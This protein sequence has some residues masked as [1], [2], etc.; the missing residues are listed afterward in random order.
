MATETAYIGEELKYK[1]VI[2]SQGF[3]MADDDFSAVAVCGSRKV[4][5]RKQDFLLDQEGNY[6][7]AI[8]T[9]Q[10]RKGELCLVTYAYVPDSDFP[11]GLRTEV[12]KQ[13]LV[14]LL[15]PLKK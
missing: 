10:F 9:T 8:D 7:L 13:R 3:S 12:D 1:V 2:T 4:T 5:Y 6:Y 15:D 11:D 14:T